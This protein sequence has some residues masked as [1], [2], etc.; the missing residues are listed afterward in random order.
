MGG[1]DEVEE[2]RVGWRLRLRKVGWSCGG[3]VRA[4]RCGWWVRGGEV[5]DVWWWWKLRKNSLMVGLGEGR[6]I[7]AR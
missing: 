1:A 4:G 6:D 5:I 7:F 2:C 3:L